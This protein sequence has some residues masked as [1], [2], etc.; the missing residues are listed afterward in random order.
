MLRY[1]DKLYS[2]IMKVSNHADPNLRSLHK[3]SGKVLL[4]ISNLASLI[5]LELLFV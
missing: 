2:Q 4:K 5:T 1:R 3:N